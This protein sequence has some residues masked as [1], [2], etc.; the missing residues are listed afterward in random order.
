MKGLGAASLS[1]RGPNSQI[2]LVWEG[3]FAHQFPKGKDSLDGAG[4]WP[5]APAQ[6][7]RAGADLLPYLSRSACT[8]EHER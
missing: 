4:T 2:L 3:I 8:P 6:L 7:L 5:A 1:Q